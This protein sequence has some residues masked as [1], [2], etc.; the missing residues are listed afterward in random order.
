[1]KKES[2]I[3][4]CTLGMGGHSKELLKRGYNV[5]GIDRDENAIKRAKENLKDF[6]NIR[7][8]HDNFINLRKILD[9]LKIKNGLNKI[10]NLFP[11]IV[12]ST[13]PKSLQSL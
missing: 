9:K 2:L 8:V 6:K 7:F 1:M 12:T 11:H 10:Q 4:D 3:V 5:I 13:K